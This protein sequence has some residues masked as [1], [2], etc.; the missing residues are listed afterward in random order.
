[1]ASTRWRLLYDELNIGNKIKY[2]LTKLM[3]IKITLDFPSIK[4]K[5]NCFFLKHY[6]LGANNC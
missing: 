3:H 6:M 4:K 5:I 1:M 2:Y